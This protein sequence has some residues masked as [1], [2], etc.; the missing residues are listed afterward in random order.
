MPIVCDKGGAQGSSDKGILW[1]IACALG[2]SVAACSTPPS[3]KPASTAL[4]AVARPAIAPGTRFV[5][6][7]YRTGK[8]ESWVVEKVAADGSVTG[9]GFGGCSFTLTE[10]GFGPALAWND[11]PDDL[12]A[13]RSG[14]NTISAHEGGLFPLAVGNTE[15]WTFTSRSSTGETGAD[16]RTCTVT[17][18]VRL[19]TRDGERDAFKVVCDGRWATRVAYLGPDGNLIRSTE[20]NKK[21]GMQWDSEIVRIEPPAV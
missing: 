10:L 7:D 4:A 18:T 19:L 9:A 3:D 20:T 21:R 8:E 2:I 16:T 6:W 15:S 5:E 12:P 13:W 11:C 17:S 14:T 1:P